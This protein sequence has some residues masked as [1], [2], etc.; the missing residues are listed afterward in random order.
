MPRESQHTEWK[1]SWQEDHL[2]WVCGFANAE[3]GRLEIG[4]DNRGHVVG[5]PDAARLLEELPNKI[6]DLLG[7]LVAVNLHDADG[8][9]W[10]EIVVDAYPNPISYR[11]HYYVRSGSTL[12]ELRGAALDRFLLGKQGR[13]WDGLPVPSVTVKDLSADA[14]ARFRRLAERS[15]RIDLKALRE[16]DAGLL[17]KLRLTDGALLKRAAVLLFHPDPATVAAGAFVKLGYFD[18]AGELLYHDEVQGDLFGQVE[19]TLDLLLTKY[20]KAAIRYEGVQ[21][22]ERFPVPRAALREALLNALVHRDYAVGAPVQVRVQ[23]DRLKLWNPAVLPE[24]WTLDKLLGEHAS[25]PFNP[26][27]ANAFFRAGE[28]EAWGQGIQ[29]IFAA[30]R[31]AGTPAP[32]LRYEPNDLWLE[33]PFAPEHIAS[34][35]TRT[36]PIATPITPQSRIV[37]LIRSNPTISQ[38]V[39]AKE[40]GL[41]LDGVKYTLGRLKEAGVIRR[42]GPNRGGVWE[43]IMRSAHEAETDTGATPGYRRGWDSNPRVESPAAKLDAPETDPVTDLNTDPV[44]R[45][46]RQLARGPL[47]PSE[48]QKR[49]GLKHRPTFRTNYLYPA[50]KQAVIEPTL[51]EKLRS[52]LQRYRLTPAG[53]RLLQQI[54]NP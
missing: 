19:R 18:A 38:A 47:S 36:T 21:R 6:R 11:G 42:V 52:R 4:R 3:G 28:I 5:L 54:R 16:T 24:G 13:T 2:R 26:T 37:E 44:E 14:I 31:E 33:F 45:L 12:Q 40:V 34:T 46:V 48:L 53:Q 20:L 17:E 43:I 8:K 32:E 25:Q 22:I 41:S 9:A 1:A 23:D 39:L 51:P 35:V 7:I 50:L 10:L 49:L 29:R 30:C 15:G 27:L